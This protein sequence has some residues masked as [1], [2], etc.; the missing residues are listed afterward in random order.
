MAYQQARVSAGQKQLETEKEL[1]QLQKDAGEEA[2]DYRIRILESERNLLETRI[3]MVEAN[4]IEEYNLRRAV[5]DKEYEIAVAT[6]DKEKKNM[7][8]KNKQLLEAQLNYQRDLQQIEDDFT[9]GYL[10]RIKDQ[11]ATAVANTVDEWKRAIPELQGLLNEYQS[12]LKGGKAATQTVDEWEKEL[13]QLRDSIRKTWL[14][15]FE[16]IIGAGIKKIGDDTRKEMQFWAQDTSQYIKSEA[17]GYMQFFQDIVSEKNKILGTLTQ[18]EGESDEQFRERKLQA[19]KLY[20]EK[21]FELRKNAVEKY[22]QWYYRVNEEQTAA[23]LESTRTTYEDYVNGIPH[24]VWDYMFRPTDNTMAQLE[25]DLQNAED[26][27]TVAAAT[28]KEVMAN[29]WAANG[30]G[31]WTP[32]DWEEA[33]AMLPE[34][35]QKDYIAKLENLKDREQ[36]ILKQR[37]DN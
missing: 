31:E 7:T 15:G 22:Y 28:I 32:E 37:L 25:I 6:A 13:A 17:Y 2:L 23:I 30:N 10:Q 29:L 16:D 21:V 20:D 35:V 36:V 1:Y 24:N 9:A 19:E 34:D 33:F 3:N 12:K 8:L 26:S 11:T 14:N 5:A 4:T 18:L 27:F